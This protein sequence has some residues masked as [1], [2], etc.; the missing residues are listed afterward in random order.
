MRCDQCGIADSEVQE[1]EFDG[2]WFCAH[3]GACRNAMLDA[4]EIALEACRHE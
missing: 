4:Y 1:E 3:L 2:A